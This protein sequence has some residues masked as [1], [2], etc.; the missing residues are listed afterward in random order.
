MNS[1]S[2]NL[3]KN[4]PSYTNA[5]SNGSIN[6]SEQEAKERSESGYS[7]EIIDIEQ[8]VQSMEERKTLLAS[9]LQQKQ[10]RKLS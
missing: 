2:V 6:M 9:N 5:I 3:S 8:R 10:D 1:D 4:R 7:H